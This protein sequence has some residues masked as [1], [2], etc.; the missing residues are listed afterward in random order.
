MLRLRRSVRPRLIMIFALSLAAC[1]TTVRTHWTQ[2]EAENTRQA[3]AD[4]LRRYPTAMW[5][6]E[7]QRRMTDAGHAFLATCKIGGVQAFKGFISSHGSDELASLARAQLQFLESIK[8]HDIGSYKRFVSQNPEHLF[9]GEAKAALPLLWLKYTGAKVGVRIDVGELM[10]KGVLLGGRSS[11]DG[12]RRSIAEG[13]TRELE[14]EQ[15]PFVI[16]DPTQSVNI[17]RDITVVLEVSYSESSAETPPPDGLIDALIAT[18]LTNALLK[19]A[20]E[21]LRFS[22]RKVNETTVYYSGCRSLRMEKCGMELDALKAVGASNAALIMYTL[23]YRS[24][25]D[26]EEQEMIERL[27]QAAHR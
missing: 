13:L 10:W 3:Y 20:V 6:E 23:R 1:G 24:V 27:R 22:V 21:D 14:Q 12:I 2:A 4:F 19:P 8:P 7:A 5:A 18:P 11:P 17:P 26:S 25:A 9:V 16:V 15:I